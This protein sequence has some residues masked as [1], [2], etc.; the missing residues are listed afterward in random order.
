MS[1]PFQL[2]VVPADRDDAKNLISSNGKCL[3]ERMSRI[4]PPTCPVAPTIPTR[5]TSEVTDDGVAVR[6]DLL[7]VF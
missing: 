7:I 1:D 2:I 5:I 3:S 6:R 4:T